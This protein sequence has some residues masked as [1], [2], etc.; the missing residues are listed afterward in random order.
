MR[1]IGVRGHGPS[2]GPNPR[3]FRPPF[4]RLG[5]TLFG[6]S[7]GSGHQLF[8]SGSFY[9]LARGVLEAGCEEKP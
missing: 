8:S 5:P 1:A 7:E 6:H 2:P 9:I 4:A 3:A